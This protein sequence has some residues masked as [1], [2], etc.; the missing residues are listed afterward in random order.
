[1]QVKYSPRSGAVHGVLS[2]KTSTDITL[3][4]VVERWNRV[5]ALG[6]AC[7]FP[8]ITMEPQ[9]RLRGYTA[10]FGSGW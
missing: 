6:Y 5:N 7:R 10:T 1:M 3:H 2:A 9:M 4:H 8:R